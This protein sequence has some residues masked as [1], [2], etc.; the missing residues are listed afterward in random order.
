[1]EDNGMFVRRSWLEIDLGILADNLEI[2]RKSIPGCH[3][4]MAV[5]KANAYGHGDVEVA[6]TLQDEGICDFAVSNIEEA[7]RL[8]RAGIR[9]Q[10]LILGYTPVE[11]AGILAENDITQALLDTSYAQALANTGITVKAQFAIDTGMNR[12]GLDAMDPLACEQAIRRYS[13]SFRLTG[14][15][16]HLCLADTD[17]A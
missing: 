8:R 12:I 5:V 6:K 17:S 13:S 11:L 3:G 1:M 4:I 2:Y 9:G 14:L 10:V 15:F 7:L 16:T